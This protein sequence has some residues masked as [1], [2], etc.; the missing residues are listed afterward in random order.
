MEQCQNAPRRARVNV[1]SKTFNILF[2]KMRGVQGRLKYFRK[3]IRFGKFGLP[4]AKLNII[5]FFSKFPVV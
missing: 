1:S 2:P 5:T 3:F 4:Y